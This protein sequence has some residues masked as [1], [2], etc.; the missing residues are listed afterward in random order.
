MSTA[1]S[2]ARRALPFAL[3]IA[4]AAGFGLAPW[5]GRADL[6]LLDIHFRLLRRADPRPAPVPE[7][8]I[9]GIDQA[10]LAAIPEP[11]ALYHRP[12]GRFLEAMAQARPRAVG[13]DFALPEHSMD[14]VL[15]GADEQ[16]LRGILALRGRTPLVLGRMLGANSLPRPVHPPLAALA[17]E[18]GLGYVVAPQDPDRVV[19]RYQ[20]FLGIGGTAPVLA[21]SLAQACG[22]PTPAMIVDFTLGPAFA[23]VPL[24]QVLEWQEAGRTDLLRD[25]FQGRVVL[26]GTV[27]PFDDRVNIPV[28]LASWEEPGLNDS[29]GVLLHAQT[30]RSLLAGSGIQPLKGGAGFIMALAGALAGFALATA[31]RRGGLVVLGLLALTEVCAVLLLRQ[32]LFLPVLACGGPGASAWFLAW[33]RARYLDKKAR[34]RAEAATRAQAEFLARMS[35]E[36]RTPMNA[37]LGLTHLAQ[38]QQASAEV[39][40][41]LRKIKGAS[42][43]LMSILNDVL[44]FSKIEAGSLELE[45]TPFAIAGVLRQV[46]DLFG[47]QARHQ[48]LSWQVSL[49]AGVPPV[50]VGDPLRLGQILANLAGNALKFTRA[51]SVQVAV[52][53][54]GGAP[55]RPRL[56]FAVA[57]TGI[58]LSEGER[59]H[60]FQ[61]FTQANPAIS[62]EFGGT[63]LGLAIS[64]RLA[65]AMGG[66]LTV[67]SVPGEGSTFSFEAAFA[68]G[69]ALPPEPVR[70][71]QDLQGLRVLVVE[72]D[73]IN[74][75]VVRAVL[76]GAGA[77]VTLAGTARD[78]VRLALKDRPQVV[79]TDLRL[80][81]LD[82][83]ELVRRIWH[84]C[85]GLPVLAMTANASPAIQE[86]CRQAGV[87]E[88]LQKPFEPEELIRCLGAWVTPAASPAPAT[89]APAPVA[90]GPGVSFAEALKRLGGNRVLLRQLM[91]LFV[92]RYGSAAEAIRAS[93]AA[94]DRSD[95]GLRL[96]TLRGAA[97]SLSATELQ[98]ACA[99][100]EQALRQEQPG[101]LTGGLEDLSQQ[102]GK[103]L[104]SCLQVQDP[105]S[106]EFAATR[107]NQ[108]ETALFRAE[109]QVQ[110]RMR[111]PDAEFAAAQLKSCLEGTAQEASILEVQRLIQTFDYPAALEILG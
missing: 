76:R 66:T 59:E 51:G 99:A 6:S 105:P 83:L 20:P 9:V 25:R 81:D 36:I 55:E 34:L 69:A 82:G 18:S 111:S 13:V 94:G 77:A 10:T 63:G 96:H 71:Q 95:A 35:H 54:E 70:V 30:L 14:P 53:L 80:P 4:L 40:E 84:D 90:P 106:R 16:L 33:A 21:T 57:D 93:L 109:L 73:P 19:R 48:G 23:L 28:H 62:R 3:A 2:H 88:V 64:R 27:L 29:P 50:L 87:A 32:G 49:G 45:A 92:A 26:L 79:L 100:L 44:D 89:V 98:K 11:M 75:E 86:A 12:L 78:G 67:T 101:D 60:L 7:V 72:D 58:G 110:L 107:G 46:E 52:C 8:V 39:L 68:L 42:R 5:A 17:G 85:P 91:V 103:V 97:A 65:E 61:A 102:L 41:Y 15:S 56:R 38:R 24:H 47:A 104:T 1:P 74:Q 37:I 22:R 108:A 43:A 31:R